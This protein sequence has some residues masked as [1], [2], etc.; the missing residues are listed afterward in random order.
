[1]VGVNVIERLQAP[2][3]ID[4]SGRNLTVDD[5]KCLAGL[6]V[7]LGDAVQAERIRLWVGADEE[8]EEDDDEEPLGYIPL[9]V[10]P[11]CDLRGQMIGVLGAAFLSGFLKFSAVLKT[12]NLGDNAIA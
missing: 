9:Q 12:L 2:G 11:D 3:S 6:C 8:Q 7:G 1:M 10:D 5:A 4:W